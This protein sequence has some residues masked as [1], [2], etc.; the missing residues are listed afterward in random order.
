MS[1]F[2]FD[3][4]RE[5]SLA[6]RE[7]TMSPDR[8]AFQNYVDDLKYNQRYRDVRVAQGVYDSLPRRPTRLF[9]PGNNGNR[10]NGFV[11]EDIYSKKAWCAEYKPKYDHSSPYKPIRSEFLTLPSH[12]LAN[13]YSTLPKSW[14]ISSNNSYKN[15]FAP[16]QPAPTTSD[17]T[18]SPTYNYYRRPRPKG[19]QVQ[20]L[21]YIKYFTDERNFD[22]A[23]TYNETHESLTFKRR[24]SV[25]DPFLWY[26]DLES[27]K[28]QR[29]RRPRPESIVYSQ[30][31]PFYPQDRG[32]KQQRILTQ[33]QLQQ[34]YIAEN[35]CLTRSNNLVSRRNECETKKNVTFSE[36]SGCEV[37]KN[38]NG[39]QAVYVR[40]LEVSFSQVADK[41]NIGKDFKPNRP[42][43]LDKVKSLP[44]GHCL[45]GNGNGIDTRKIPVGKLPLKPGQPRGLFA[46]ITKR[47]YLSQVT[48]RTHRHLFDSL[49]YFP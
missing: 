36:V 22:D 24:Q 21:R 9:Q 29:T 32:K 49:T 47:K 11:Y 7:R 43:V 1:T 27:S 2:R 17:L 13:K 48:F 39:K 20:S 19:D 44:N 5:Y 40:E 8:G 28:I 15:H 33:Q 3:Y 18:F 46:G 16:L 6:A 25:E 26:D 34:Q 37:S 42:I 4:Q 14:S 35:V 38:G 23:K 30:K 41:C 12:I 45:S 31:D 10:R